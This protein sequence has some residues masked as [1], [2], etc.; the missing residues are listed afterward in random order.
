MKLFFLVLA[1]DEAYVDQKI[2]ELRNLDVPFLVVCGSKSDLANVVYRKPMGKY[3]AINFGAG[4]VPEDI[5]VVALNDVDT[6]IYNVRGALG[7]FSSDNVG[8]VCAKVRIAKGPQWFFGPMIDF[9]RKKL[10][11]AAAGDLMLVR[12]KV[13]RRIL[14]VEPCKAE[15]SYILF[16]VLGLGQKAIFSRECQVE[17]EKTESADEEQAYK[18]RTVC[19][20]YQALARTDPP[21]Y[22]KAFYTLLPIISPLLMI[23]GRKGYFWMRGILLGLMDYL[24]GDISGVW[25]SV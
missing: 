7:Y 13:L 10:P 23:L 1:R 17:T 2:K 11:I 8:L 12:H 19:G 14:P 21:Y 5:D 4:L 9:I 15:D 25:Q 6:K 18:R 24:R 3:D 20:I 16:R 22:I